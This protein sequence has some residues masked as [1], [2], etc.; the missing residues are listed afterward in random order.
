[1]AFF[2]CKNKL[3]IFLK[4]FFDIFNSAGKEEGGGQ[5]AFFQAR[6]PAFFSAPELTEFETRCSRQKDLW[7]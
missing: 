6:F 4:F 7:I 2:F 1:M 3:K 5:K